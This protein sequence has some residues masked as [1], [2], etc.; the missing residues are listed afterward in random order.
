MR[1]HPY[2]KSSQ[3]SHKL[4][5]RPAIVNAHLDNYA[6]AAQRRRLAAVHFPVADRTAARQLTA[7]ACAVAPPRE[8]KARDA[9][10]AGEALPDAGEPDRHRLA[11]VHCGD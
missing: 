1:F 6:H 10:A 3:S 4:A 11:E 9:F 2:G 8:G 7:F 5:P